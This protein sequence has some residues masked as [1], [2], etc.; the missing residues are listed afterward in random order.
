MTCN[1]EKQPSCWAFVVTDTD[2]IHN[3]EKLNQ[4]PIAY[5]LKGHSLACDVLCPLY[6]TWYKDCRKCNRWAMV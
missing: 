6:G 3:A 2:R 5:A 1:E 4:I